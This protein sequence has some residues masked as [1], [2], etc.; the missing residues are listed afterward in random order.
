[1]VVDS[2]AVAAL[3]LGEPGAD[4]I[5]R[6]I[7]GAA[8]S[9]VNLAETIALFARKGMSGERIDRFLDPLDLTVV[10]FDRARAKAAGLLAP[11]TG[12]AGLSL[13][14]RACL[15]LAHE[16][17]RPALTGDRAWLRVAGAVK[18]EVRLFR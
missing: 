3:I 13:G 18:V 5:E 9:A 17:H 14:D 7:E 4:E 1:M 15:A 11:L 12:Q 8:I 16:L 10:A 2:S 6:L